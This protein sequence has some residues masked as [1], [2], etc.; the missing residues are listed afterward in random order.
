MI[1]KGFRI[2]DSAVFDRLMVSA[3]DGCHVEFRRHL[4]G[5]E[6]GDDEEE[7]ATIDENK[8]V[9]PKLLQ[10]SSRW[11]D[12]RQ[13]LQSFLRSTL[14]LLSEAKEPALLSFV[15]KSLSHYVPLLTPFPKLAKSYLQSLLKLWSAPL[16]TSEDYQ[17]V[18]LKSFLRIRQLAV[19]QPF[20]FV[21][22]CLKSSYLSYARRAKFG[23]AAS[24]HSALPTLT[25]MGNCVVE[26]YSLDYASS[27]SHAFVYVRQLALHLRNALQKR[28]SESLRAVYCWQYVH[29]LRLWAAVL[30]AACGS[31]RGGGGGG[32]VEAGSTGTGGDDESKLMRS[33]VYPLTEVVFGTARLVP[34]A[35]HLPLRLH[36]VRMLQQVASASE[37]FIPTTSLLLDALDLKELRL[38]PKKVKAGKSDAVS[39]AI[40]LP[41]TLKLPKETALRTVEQTDACL[42][43]LFVLLG[44]EVDLYRYSPAFPEFAVRVVQRLRQFAKETKNGKYRAYARGCIDSCERYS[45]QAVA[46]RAELMEAPKDVRRLEALKPSG[47]P[48]MGERHDVALA[49]ERRLEE[50]ARPKTKKAAGEQQ[51]G[52][53]K[54]GA[55]KRGGKEEDAEE[56]EEEDATEQGKKRTRKG[57]KKKKKAA[58]VNENDLKNE[59]ALK[60]KDQVHEGIDWSDD[61]DRSGDGMDASD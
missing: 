61:D 10:R 9:N 59:G 49:K 34:T 35:R 54:K 4:L 14:H 13:S 50:A 55:T 3:L 51:G 28:T 7:A 39:L 56:E 21:E 23:T 2:D 32:A 15:L 25:F 53:K 33:L 47:T 27:Y 26:L 22:D 57:K 48:S 43:E 40:R 38:K 42:S 52:K 45:A 5:A 30:S 24:V 8:P 19:T 11:D 17:A 6:G 1:K 37:T 31:S 36:C 16:D 44:R 20:P 18:R 29:C 41:V 12:L 60:Q 58:E 46:A